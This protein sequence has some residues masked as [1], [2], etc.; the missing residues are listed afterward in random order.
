MQKRLF[1]KTADLFAHKYANTKNY[2][3]FYTKFRR[4]LKKINQKILEYAANKSNSGI[5]ALKIPFW[6][7]IKLCKEQSMKKLRRLLSNYIY[8]STLGL[9]LGAIGLIFICSYGIYRIVK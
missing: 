8:W 2:L 5:S 7:K 1:T 6:R 3:I 9:I 4:F